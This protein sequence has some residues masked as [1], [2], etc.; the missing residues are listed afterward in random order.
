MLHMAYIPAS[1]NYLRQVWLK[2]CMELDGDGDYD[3]IYKEAEHPIGEAG[4][5]FFQEP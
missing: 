3:D 4:K 1:K 2:A 5:H